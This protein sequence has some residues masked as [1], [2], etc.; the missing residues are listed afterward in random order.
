MREKM[1][2]TTRG[3]S[4]APPPSD[5]FLV[6]PTELGRGKMTAALG[7][8]GVHPTVIGRSI[9]GRDVECFTLGR[10]RSRV[11]YFGTHHASESVCTNVLYMLAA[12]LSGKS[13][14]VPATAGIDMGILLRRYTYHI[15]PCLNPDGVEL[16]YFGVGESPLAERQLRMSGGSF[17][18]WQANARGVDLNHNYEA[19]FYAYKKIERERGTLAGSTLYSGEYPESEPESRAAAVL[20]RTLYPSA[21]VS[22]HTQGEEIFFGPRTSP[23]AARAAER[24]SRLLGYRIGEPTGTAAYGGLCDYTAALGI[25]S[26]TVELGRGKNPL[27]ESSVPALYARALRAL[28]LLPTLV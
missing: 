6:C 14:A 25:P 23:A 22:L 2:K 10:G 3:E 20:V 8:Y 21:V 13:P 9:L 7:K 5:D 17:A 19:G 16:R 11:I 12:V 1:I 27:P 24:L 28:I 4:Y 18:T 26:F 15:I